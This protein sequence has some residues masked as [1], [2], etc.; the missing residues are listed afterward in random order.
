MQD[1][2]QS[3]VTEVVCNSLGIAGNFLLIFESVYWIPSIA[4]AVYKT[5]PR[6]PC[7][8]LIVTVYQLTPSM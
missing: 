7:S 3:D 4:S 5:I 1:C 6:N 8:G 2:G